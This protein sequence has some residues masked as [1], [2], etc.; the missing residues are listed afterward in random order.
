MTPSGEQNRFR[1]AVFDLERLYSGS[2][3][4]ALLSNRWPRHGALWPT[5]VRRGWSVLFLTRLWQ[6]LPKM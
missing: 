3:A 5:T 2:L 1:T 6:K 4:P